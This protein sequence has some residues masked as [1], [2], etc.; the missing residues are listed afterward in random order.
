MSS[1]TLRVRLAG[2][3]TLVLY[4]STARGHCHPVETINV[5][6]DEPVTIERTLP[7]TPFIDG[8]WYWFDVVAGPR[9]TTLI[10]ADWLAQA[11]P[12]PAAPPGRISIGIT[13]FNRPDDVV[14]QLRTLGEASEIHG[15]LD[16][17]YVI[18]QGTQP[19]EGPSGLR[20]RGQEARRPAAGDRAGKP[21]RLR[22]VR[23]LH[24]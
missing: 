12:G 11:E 5:R 15:L 21:R 20:R 4:R 16:T 14:E 3:S 22:R 19:G 2:E 8:G 1:V 23:P 9:G 13:T 24:G 17:V 7:L 10:E 6:S 18:D